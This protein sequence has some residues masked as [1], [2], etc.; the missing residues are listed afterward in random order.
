MSSQLIN[1]AVAGA[2]ASAVYCPNDLVVCGN[3][4]VN[5]TFNQLS[6]V[7]VPIVP[8]GV[9]GTFFS[10][11]QSWT[12]TVQRIGLVT[13]TMYSIAGLGLS[14]T[15]GVP[16]TQAIL[17]LPGTGGPDGT[18]YNQPCRVRWWCATPAGATNPGAADNREG[19][20][21]YV[22]G[23]KGTPALFVLSNPAPYDEFANVNINATG[24]GSATLQLQFYF[25]G[26]GGTPAG[27]GTVNMYLEIDTINA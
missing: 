26:G 13:R 2:S 7:L 12:K 8:F 15:G 6:S 21:E 5:G 22:V 11:N 19:A 3:E 16:A 18:L 14:G 20:F 24:T 4:T 17:L 25:A 23:A 1:Q 9:S 10:G 27:S